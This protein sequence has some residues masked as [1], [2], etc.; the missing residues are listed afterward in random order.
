MCV[1]KLIKDI[2]DCRKEM[3]EMASYSSLTSPQVVDI[4]KKLDKLLNL[5]EKRTKKVRQQL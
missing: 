5:Y 4:S 2:E 1:C 3:I